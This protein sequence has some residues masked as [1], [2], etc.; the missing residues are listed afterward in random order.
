MHN[1][2]NNI[3]LVTALVN[4][5]MTLVKRKIKTCPTESDKY[6]ILCFMTTCHQRAVIQSCQESRNFQAAQ[7]PLH[8]LRC[9]RGSLS[10]GLF[11]FF[12]II[13]SS[14][15][16]HCVSLQFSPPFPSIEIRQGP[17]RACEY[18]SNLFLSLSSQSNAISL[19]W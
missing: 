10:A 12:L 5:K 18:M 7:R 13:Y 3:N 11:L 15:H 17:Q 16:S 4:I 14:H 9:Q 1:E 8:Q 2:N 19:H 6:N